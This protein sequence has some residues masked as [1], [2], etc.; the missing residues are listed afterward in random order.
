MFSAVT[1]RESMRGAWD[2]FA[3]RHGSIYHGAAFRDLLLDSFGYRCAYHAILGSD[4]R[5][6]AL[7]PLVV[8]RNLGM[9]KAAVSLPFVNYLD[10]CAESDEARTAAVYFLQN[11][12]T[13]AGIDYVELRLQDSIFDCPGWG[14]RLENYTFV[15]PLHADEEQVLSRAGSGCRNHVRKVYR[16]NWFAASYD[17]KYLDDFSRVYSIRMKQLGSPSPDIVF[18]R[19]FFKRMPETTRLLTVIDQESGKV[20]G[21]MLLL[22]SERDST[23]F[24]PFGANLVEYNNRY[25]N[26]FMY[27]EAVRLGIKL[28]LGGLDLGRS[29]AGSGTFTYK[30][31]WG[32]QARPLRYLTY[33]GHAGAAGAP[34]REKFDLAVACWKRLPKVITDQVGKRIIRYVLP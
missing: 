8:S 7:L 27:W 31:Q 24:F 14:E 25:L 2:K 16:N 29:Q 12:R 20:A 17:T 18:F 9:K 6:C 28:G 26:S 15:L 22:A 1:Y 32:A 30:L 11:Y 19:N 33:N 5:I 13:D 10:I 23:L 21:G 34:D 4:D 3:F